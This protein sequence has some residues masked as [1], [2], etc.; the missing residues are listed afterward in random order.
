[1]FSLK[2]AALSLS[3]VLILMTLIALPPLFASFADSI[4]P[5]PAGFVCNDPADGAAQ[6]VREHLVHFGFVEY[7]SADELYGEVAAGRLDCGVVIPAGAS[8]RLSSGDLEGLLLFID[9]PTALR[10]DLWREAAAAALYA[11]Y[12]PY[13][14]VDA[15][16]GSGISPDEVHAVYDDLISSGYLFTFEIETANGAA[17][18]VQ[19]R[20]TQF[21]LFASAVLVFVGV[22]F[23][24]CVPVMS[25]FGIMATRL[26][27]PRALKHLMLPQLLVRNL[28][29]L[30]SVGVG[31]RIAGFA[32]LIPA[33]GLYIVP[34]NC[35][36]FI[37][38]SLIGGKSWLTIYTTLVCIA[39]V[40]LCPVFTDIKLIVPA[41][42][43][44]RRL[45]P[46]YWLWMICESLTFGIL[47]GAASICLAS[48]ILALR[49]KRKA[50]LRPL[51]AG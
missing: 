44:L 34:L 28:L 22:I 1:L 36:G 10:S 3:F 24:V 38:L 25:D 33:L 19:I 37:L 26:G 50:L 8:D 46:T 5:V 20:K 27:A 30:I 40:A 6:K 48:A 41:V 39:S 16:S 18:P 12:A 2:R 49:L 31:L 51:A 45:C 15:L 42:G 9:S 13:I 21:V 32:S 43:L 29:I 7:D 17:E 47:F 14:T 23:G 11:V 4:K 35:A